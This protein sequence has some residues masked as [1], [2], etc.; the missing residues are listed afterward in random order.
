MRRFAR[1]LSRNMAHGSQAAS[2]LLGGLVLGT[3]IAVTLLSQDV[4]AITGWA[5]DVLGAGFLT[6][7]SA[8]I[9]TTLFGLVRMNAPGITDESREYWFA[10]GMQATNGVTT[11]ALTFTLLGISLGI[12]S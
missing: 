1:A 8:L 2:Y 7:L 5:I 9:F 12:G 4:S 10:V 11:L 6:L 3:A